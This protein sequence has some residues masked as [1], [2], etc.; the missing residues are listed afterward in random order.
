[1]AVGLTVFFQILE[2]RLL[3]FEILKYGLDDEI[4]ITHRF[5]E[6]IAGLNPGEARRGFRRS[7]FPLLDELVETALDISFGLVKLNGRNIRQGH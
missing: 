5:A 3:E 7:Q 6:R 4:S 1:M 2:N